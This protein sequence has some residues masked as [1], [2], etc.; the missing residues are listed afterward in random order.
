MAGGRLSAVL[1]CCLTRGHSKGKHAPLSSLPRRCQVTAR[2]AT[3]CAV[4]EGDE[5]RPGTHA[6]SPARRAPPP[7]LRRRLALPESARESAP[8]RS[9]APSRPS[10][11]VRREHRGDGDRSVATTT[12]WV[13]V[14]PQRRFRLRKRVVPSD[15]RMGESLLKSRRKEEILC[16]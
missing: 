14:A 11:R 7:R 1:W 15:A 3:R 5:Y 13:L 9:L 16:F 10:S 12:P 2:G 6:P 4:D 8:P